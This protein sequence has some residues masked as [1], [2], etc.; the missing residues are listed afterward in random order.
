M[1]S[2]QWQRF[3]GLLGRV[4]DH[5]VAAAAGCSVQAVYQRRKALGVRACDARSEPA[6]ADLAAELMGDVARLIDWM[7]GK[8]TWK[9]LDRAI[10]VPPDTARRWR[11]GARP[12]PQWAVA[13]LRRWLVK[14]TPADYPPAPR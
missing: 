1:A 2:V 4:E 6:P 11:C 7:D 13:P 5:L 14:H 9:G 10:G 8:L 3:D 12:L